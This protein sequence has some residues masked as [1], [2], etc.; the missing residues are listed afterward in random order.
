MPSALTVPASVPVSA[1]VPRAEAHAAS[2]RAVRDA[3][4]AAIDAGDLE[5][6]QALLNV[7]RSSTWK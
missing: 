1:S 5:R 3:I 4:K 2:D 7:L 6:A